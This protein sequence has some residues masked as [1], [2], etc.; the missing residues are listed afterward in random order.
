MNLSRENFSNESL[1]V[2]DQVAILLYLSEQVLSLNDTFKSNKHIKEATSDAKEI[3]DFA[4]SVSKSLMG[5]LFH[6]KNNRRTKLI[7]A[8]DESILDINSVIEAA[9]RLQSLEEMD[10]KGKGSVIAIGVLARL[11]NLKRIWTQEKS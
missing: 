1:K 2:M 7:D 4:R 6:S 10:T 8:Y 5:A 11:E 3:L 9:K